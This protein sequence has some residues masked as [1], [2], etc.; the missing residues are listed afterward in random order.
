[1]TSGSPPPAPPGDA[2]LQIARGALRDAFSAVR[3]LEQLLKAV[4]VG[5]RALRG[6]IPDV[7]ASCRPMIQATQ[8]LLDDMAASIGANCHRTLL[9]FTIPRMLELESALAGARR[10]SLR[11]SQR[12]ALER[13]TSRVVRELGTVLMLIDL[14]HEGTTSK[15]VAVDLRE[16][17]QESAA[18][19]KTARPLREVALNLSCPEP[20]S[21]RVRPRMAMAL[22]ALATAFVGE[23]SRRSVGVTAE[24]PEQGNP[25]LTFFPAAQEAASIQVDVPMPFEAERAS[26]EALANATGASYEERADGTVVITFPA[27]DE[28]EE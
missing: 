23:R 3:N 13:V 9:D 15:T 7:H 12:L 8:K 5:P 25:R 14:L 20:I 4:R 1:M 16:L 22:L 19:F 18:I 27:A 10:G 17:V 26:A 2:R 6:V 21:V 28:D 24:R 11:A